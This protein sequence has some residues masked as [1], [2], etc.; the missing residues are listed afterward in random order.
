[1]RREDNYFCRKEYMT[2]DLKDKTLVETMKIYTDLWAAE[3]ESFEAELNEIYKTVIDAFKKIIE[4][5][6]EMGRVLGRAITEFE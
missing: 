6:Q 5:I 1:M 2:Y 3:R 4:Q